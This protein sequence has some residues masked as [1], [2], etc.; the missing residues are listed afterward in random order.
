[1][2]V[3]AAR[4]PAVALSKHNLLLVVADL[5]HPPPGPGDVRSQSLIFT[6]GCLHTPCPAL[7][8]FAEPITDGRED[9][10]V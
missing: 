4:G 3:G 7:L 2:D 10:I 8:L 9:F 1:M 6:A 5:K